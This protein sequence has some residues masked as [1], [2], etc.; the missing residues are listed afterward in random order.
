MGFSRSSSEESSPK[1]V[2]LERKKRKLERIEKPKF[3]YFQSKI[4]QK[5]H[6]HVFKVLFIVPRHQGHVARCHWAFTIDKNTKN[7]NLEEESSESSIAG[8]FRNPPAK[9]RK[10]LRIA[11]RGDISMWLPLNDFAGPCEISQGP[12]KCAKS[13]L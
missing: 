1:D 11:K 3:Y 6:R 5:M 4:D 12:A 9:F 7:Y 8:Q 13:F 2:W 10:G